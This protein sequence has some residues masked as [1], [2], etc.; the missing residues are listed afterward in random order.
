MWS[1]KCTEIKLDVERVE[2]NQKSLKSRI[3]LKIKNINADRE[4]QYYKVR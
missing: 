1:I 4:C 3:E 2:K